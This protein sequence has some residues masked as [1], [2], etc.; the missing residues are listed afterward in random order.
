MTDIT[1]ITDV[2][3]IPAPVTDDDTVEITPPKRGTVR[4]YHVAVL[5]VAVLVC[6]AAVGFSVSASSSRDDATKQREAAQTQLRT[7]RDST[8]QARTK[9]LTERDQT[10][11]TLDDIALLT[12]SLHELSDLSAQEVDTVAAAHQ[13]AV[14]N[15]DSGRRV[16]RAGPAGRRSADAD[17]GQGAGHH[18]PGRRAARRDEGPAGRRHHQRVAG[19]GEPRLHPESRHDG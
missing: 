12:T 8:D 1:D 15:P 10:K 16:Q 13:L 9:L 6:A 5:G 19:P 11:A 17:A 18:H 3:P 14:T 2:T 7:Q 4:W